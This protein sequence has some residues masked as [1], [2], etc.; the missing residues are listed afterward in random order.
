MLTYIG[1]AIDEVGY[2]VD[3]VVHERLDSIPS[4]IVLLFMLSST[5][6]GGGRFERPTSGFRDLRSIAELL[7][8]GFGG[9]R[10]VPPCKPFWGSNR[11]QDGAGALVRFTLRAF[12]VYDLFSVGATGK[13]R[14]Y[15]FHPV[16]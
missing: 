13:I 14:T 16:T 9:E 6:A 4:L 1:L 3:C 12:I 5:D 8:N 15:I 7:P 10:L 11:F 2:L